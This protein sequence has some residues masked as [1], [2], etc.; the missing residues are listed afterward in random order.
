MFG[1]HRT[2][3]EIKQQLLEY[4]AKQQSK[5]PKVAESA[6]AREETKPVVE[7]SSG[8]DE[9]KQVAEQKPAQ[10]F[11]QEVEQPPVQKPKQEPVAKQENAENVAQHAKKA[12]DLFQYENGQISDVIEYVNDNIPKSETTQALYDAI[13]KYEQEDEDDRNLWGRRGDLEPYR[14][15]ILDE[16]ERLSKQV[17]EQQPQQQQPIQNGVAN[18]K[19]YYSHESGEFTS[20]P[21]GVKIVGQTSSGIFLSVD[22]EGDAIIANP[23]TDKEGKKVNRENSRVTYSIDLKKGQETEAE[24]LGYEVEPAQDGYAPA[25]VVIGGVEDRLDEAVALFRTLNKEKKVENTLSSEKKELNLPK[26]NVASGTAVP[27]F[28]NKSAEEIRFVEDFEPLVGKWM[29]FGNAQ[30]FVIDSI[31]K[32]NHS[33]YIRIFDNGTIKKWNWRWS[34]IDVDSIKTLHFVDDPT[35]AG[36]ETDRIDEQRTILNE[37][38]QRALHEKSIVGTILSRDNEVQAGALN[39]LIDKVVAEMF[40]QHPE[41]AK[42]YFDD[43]QF[44]ADF[45]EKVLKEVQNKVAKR[46]KQTKKDVKDD[47][48]ANEKHLTERADLDNVLL[49]YATTPRQIELVKDSIDALNTMLKEFTIHSKRGVWEKALKDKQALLEQ[50]EAQQ[51]KLNQLEAELKAADEAEAKKQSSSTLLDDFLK[52]NLSEEEFKEA[53]DLIGDIQDFLNSK[54]T[55][56]INGDELDSDTFRSASKLT[57]LLL[58]GGLRKFSDFCKLMIGKFGDK[59]RGSL[60]SLYLSAKASAEA[61]SFRKELDT[62]DEVYDFDVENFD[63]AKYETEKPLQNEKRTVSLQVNKGASADE[64]KEQQRQIDFINAYEYNGKKGVE[65][66]ID[67]YIDKN[68]NKLDPDELRHIFGNAGYDGTNVSQ[69]K[70][71]EGQIRNALYDEMLRRAVASG[72]K[73]VVF[74]SGCAGSGKSS[75]LRNNPKVAQIAEQA[76]VAYDA[77][78]ASWASIEKVIQIAKDAGIPQENI[79]VIQVY[80]D[81]ETNFQNTLERGINTG[82]VLSLQY[83]IGSFTDGKGKL[84]ALQDNPPQAQVICIDNRNNNGGQI[85]DIEEAKAV[86]DYDITDEQIDNLLTQIENYVERAENGK[87][88][89]DQ[90]GLTAN[91]LA[92][93]ADGL[94]EVVQGR[95]ELAIQRAGELG[96]RIQAIVLGEQSVGGRLGLLEIPESSTAEHIRHDGRGSGSGSET[97]GQKVAIP[98]TEDAAREWF[99]QHKGAKLVDKYGNTYFIKGYDPAVYRVELVVKSAKS[100]KSSKQLQPVERFARLMNAREARLV[101]SL[102]RHDNPQTEQPAAEVSEVQF[103]ELDYDADNLTEEQAFARDA[104][105][106]VL[107][108]NAKKAGIEIEFDADERELE[109]NVELMTTAMRA[110]RIKELQPISIVPHSM[111]KEQLEER[112]KALSPVE[113]DGKQIQFFNTAFKKIYKDGGLFAQIVPQLEDIFRQSEFANSEADNLAGAPRK[114]GRNNT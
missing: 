35:I 72:N 43:A 89:P 103:D 28:A 46:Q 17:V 107:L 53:Q 45:R 74:V 96:K 3:Q 23:Y 93:I 13:D 100:D 68:G 47:A 36:N 20:L 106:E 2:P 67:W 102:D 79:T 61:K 33:Y 69:F 70:A 111:N 110:Q 99:E 64:Q 84:Q 37:I 65:A 90:G 113:K 50:L 40:E 109:T 24:K 104:V 66:V 4:Y 95:P 81:V 8:G 41:F 83:F 15:A 52:E 34:A 9:Q 51:A 16:L 58:K 42:S 26:E 21:E 30:P 78:L 92:T 63:I 25:R 22:G 112:Y 12:W 101:D 1:E 86:F 91:Q 31:D 62:E 98:E 71:I 27:I 77:P 48:I 32:S 56:Q 87:G 29:Q 82:R 75:S 18:A 49:K 38:V 59:I 73:S 55:K 57:I 6:T 108:H 76:G 88:S 39:P 94:S 54:F 85:V 80:S 60:R 11:G 44:G 19:E 5:Q 14:D 97:L 114:D 7:G 105:I 10:N